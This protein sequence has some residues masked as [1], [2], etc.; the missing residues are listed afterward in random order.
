MN[1]TSKII[2]AFPCMGKSSYAKNF[3]DISIDL[4]SSNYFFHRD[5]YEN[6]TD[7]EFK[8]IPNRVPNPNGLTDYVQAIDNT[9]KLNKYKY[10][11]ISMHPKVISEVIKLGHNV[12]FILPHPTSDSYDEYESRARR[13]GNN[14]N[15]IN[16]TL[17]HINTKISDVYTSEEMK[18]I[19]VIYVPY[20]LYLTDILDRS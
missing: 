12:E 14:D 8:G 19:F 6:L 11:F 16:G 5:G 4:E 17:K 10:I 20:N 18:N 13:R 7:E 1:I 9:V 2:A 15:W 3:P